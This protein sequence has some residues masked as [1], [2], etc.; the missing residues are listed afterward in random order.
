VPTFARLRVDGQHAGTEDETAGADCRR[1]VVPVM[2]PQIEPDRRR[3]D[4]VTHCG[5][6]SLA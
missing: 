2:L 1:L 3:S 5:S 6:C 4:D